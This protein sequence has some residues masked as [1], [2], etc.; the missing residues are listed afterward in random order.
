MKIVKP[1][2][3]G[4]GSMSSHNRVTILGNLGADPTYRQ[5]GEA[6]A[7]VCDLSV[8]TS[9]RWIDRDG[10]KH[11]ET[12]WHSVQVWGRAA[13]ACR[14]HLAKG[15]QVLITGK[16][17]TESWTDKEG[18]KRWKT[19][20]VADIHRGVVFVGRPRV[21]AERTD[22]APSESDEWPEGRI[23]YDGGEDL[24]F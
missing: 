23:D 16:L 20:I 9:E 11:E 8:A 6:A 13:A 3:R 24:P 5:I 2:E 12:E 4:S 18:V 10:K 15:S 21:A 1:L 7:Q 17:R 14:D 22:R 19:R